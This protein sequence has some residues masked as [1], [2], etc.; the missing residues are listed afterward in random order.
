MRFLS[1]VIPNYNG[2]SLL[3]RFMPSVLRAVENYAGRAEV[4]FVD[5]CSTDDSVAVAQKFSSLNLVTRPQNGGFSAACNTGL[6]QAKGEIV[7]FLNTDVELAEDFFATFNEYFD[8]PDTYAVTVPGFHWQTR[9]PLDGIKVGQWRRGN[10]R[11]AKNVFLDDGAGATLWWPSFTVQGAYFFAD[12]EK[13]RALGG[14]D[15][16]L[17]PYIFEE[18]DL[19]YRARMRG[20]Q[21]YYDHRA[22]AWHD[23]SFTLNA[24][25]K[26][27]RLR[28]ISIRNQLIFTWK[29]IQSPW[30]LFSHGLFLLLRLATLNRLTWSAFLDARRMLPAIRRKRHIEQAHRVLGDADILRLDMRPFAPADQLPE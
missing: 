11:V 29:N 25:A 17:S 12:T 1:V 2:A 21:I 19:C 8:N 5:D 9:E 23:H 10:L 14:F 16:L 28:Q 26:K 15:E 4:I 6:S 18:T 7:L 20:W 3:P 13:T 30:L 24:T 22:V 27:D